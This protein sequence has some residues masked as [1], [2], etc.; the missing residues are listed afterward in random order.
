MI[1]GLEGL[2]PVQDNLSQFIEFVRAH[3]LTQ[4]EPLPFTEAYPYT[5]RADRKRL[6]RR[7]IGSRPASPKPGKP[8]IKGG[9]RAQFA[10]AAGQ[11]P[12]LPAAR[13]PD[14]AGPPLLPQRR[15]SRPGARVFVSLVD[16]IGAFQITS[17]QP[18]GAVKPDYCL[19]IGFT[20]RGLQS[21][22]MPERTLL[23]FQKP[24]HQPFVNG[25]KAQAPFVGDAGPSG[26]TN[27]TMS[28]SDFDVILFA[29]RQRRGGA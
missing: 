4:A 28:D 27:W 7:L 24:D 9:C 12:G 3:D 2:I 13:L 25:A 17:A 11:N 26:P 10:M 18:W 5:V 22:K 1:V 16:G 29:L 8:H 23:S 6:Q 19:N 20:Y 15:R 21:F 14:V